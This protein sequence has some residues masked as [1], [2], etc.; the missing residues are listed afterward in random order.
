MLLET[1][2]ALTGDELKNILPNFLAIEKDVTGNPDYS[3]FNLSLR[4]EW[5]TTGS[6]Y[7]HNL[8][9]KYLL[10]NKKLNNNDNNPNELIN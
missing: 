10:I 8:H 4:E 7:C 6:K 2:T 5:N 3:M 9:S 1:Y